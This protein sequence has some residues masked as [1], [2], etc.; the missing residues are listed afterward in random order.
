[1][2]LLT[3]TLQ[4]YEKKCTSEISPLIGQFRKL[5]LIMRL[6]FVIILIS[7]IQVSA[8]TY[9]QSTKL[10]IKLEKASIKELFKDIKKQSEFTFVY[11]VDDIEDLK[12]IDCDFSQSTVEEILDYCLKGEDM[13]YEVRD[14][15]IVIVPREKLEIAPVEPIEQPQK[16]TIKGKVSDEKGEP[17]PGVSIVVKGTT[18]GITTDVDGNYTLEIPDEAEVLVFSFIGMETQEIEILN[19]TTINVSFVSSVVG[20]ED[21]VVTALGIS[22]EKKALGYAVDEV[23]SEDIAKGGT[24]NYLK[25]LDGKVTGVNFTS[26]SSDPTSSSFIVIRGATSIAGLQSRNM[27]ASAQ[28]LFVIDGVPVGTGSIGISGNIDAGNFMSEISSDDIKSVTILKSASAT[29]LYGSEG[30]NGV[31]LVTTKS[32]TGMKKGI[33]VNVNSSVTFDQAFKALPVVDSYYAG[34]QEDEMELDDN[35][36]WGPHY[37]DVTGN[38]LQWDMV[39]QEFVNKPVSRNTENP[40]LAFLE[41]GMT[42]TNNVAVTGNYD[43]GSFRMSFANMV[44]E[45]IIPDSK[46]S[47][48]NISFDAVYNITDK[49]KV[50]GSSQYIKTYVPNKQQIADRYSGG[51]KYSPIMFNLLYQTADKQPISDWKDA[52]IHGYEGTLQNTPYLDW[53]NY[54]GNNDEMDRRNYRPYK[55][56]N[57]YF[58]AQEMIST[59]SRETFISKVQI[60][61]DISESLKLTGRTGLTSTMFHFQQRIPYNVNK[62][63]LD[64]RFDARDSENSRINTD[65]LLSFNKTFGKFSVDALAGYNIRIT[66]NQ[67]TYLGGK[68]LARPGDFSISAISKDNLG[69]SYGWGTGKYSSLYGT[70][71]LGFDNMLYLDL[72]LRKDWVGITELQKNSSIYP[73]AS[74]SWIVSESLELPT[75]VSML[76]LRGGAAQVG[77]GIPTYLNVDNYGFAPTWNGTTVGTVYGSVVNPDI[78]SE[79]NTTYETGLD[80]RFLDSRLNFDF[81]VFRKVHANQIQDIPIVSSSG[82]SSYRTNIGTVT[83]DGLELA[84][85][86]VPIRT[87]DLEWSVSTNFTQ[88]KATITDLDPSF[89]EKWIGYGDNTM[90]RLKQD[91]V[92][93]D[94]YAEEGLWRVQSGKY[95]GEIML[96]PDTGTPIEN[97]DPDNRDYLGNINPDFMMG[98]TTNL[99]YKAF[100]LDVVMSYRDGGVYVSETEKRMRDDGRSVWTLTGDGNYWEGGRSHD[101]G[102]AWPNPND[103]VYDVVR[104]TNL[105]RNTINEASYFNGVYVDPT[106]GYDAQDRNLPDD[107]YILNGENPNTTW[108]Q[109]VDKITGNTWDFPQTRT[110]DATFFKIRDISLTYDI[111]KSMTSKMK[112]QTASVSVIA[113]N[114]YLWTKSG[115]NEDPESAF[116][117]T[118]TTQGVAHF[119]QPSVRQVG[120]KLNL[121]F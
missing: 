96:K 40:T 21:V 8:S 117:G 111:P 54:L 22:R 36:S 91:E 70:T 86:L 63:L 48:N 67:T 24:T 80:S 20:L 52:W 90:L 112:M 60:D 101:G 95:K 41:T 5:L 92:M 85:T 14:K 69:T 83:S 81:T 27:A 56:T 103:V 32:G 99:K 98:F 107:A 4:I 59:Y 77:Y 43:K 94:L 109:Y 68:H 104:E 116:S 64:G 114:V 106:S 97:D 23:K 18:I 66:N 118:G 39:N 10:N 35:S 78:L 105:A 72:S 53:E 108:Y 102:F 29:A 15:V 50:T 2:K 34:G 47:R 46:T 28:P 7:L 16:K 30:G 62:Y 45:G 33:G 84:L 31:I 17:L 113:R 26:L 120:C 88:F 13:T 3:K 38:H 12:E 73:G 9:S 100:T 79:V 65:V 37:S 1:M 6:S 19:Q 74:L 76:K 58:A 119:I 44:N 55:A 61:W 110:F 87:K 25:N 121:T 115:R 93:G 57:P 89:S 42:V 49:L 51:V 71:S 75:W 11:N 82:F